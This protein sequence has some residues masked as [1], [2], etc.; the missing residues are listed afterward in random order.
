MF[1][2][3]NQ[4]VTDCNLDSLERL[5][6]CILYRKAQQKL[7]ACIVVVRLALHSYEHVMDLEIFRVSCESLLYIYRACF[8]ICLS[9][10][11][12][13]QREF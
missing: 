10:L 7:Y 4:D 6:I 11:A 5:Y 1:T 9:F 8:R 2:Y 3:Q 13:P 12:Q